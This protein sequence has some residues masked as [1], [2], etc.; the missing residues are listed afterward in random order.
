[1]KKVIL[2]SLLAFVAGHIVA[3][4]IQS[5]PVGTTLPMADIKMK[6]ISGKE[7]SINDAIKKN[8]VLVMFSCNTCPYVIKNQERTKETIALAEKNNIGVIILNS[9][10]DKREGDD[11]FEEMK[12]YAEKQ[13]YK[14][15]YTV[16]EAS[17]IADA[18]GATKTP[19]IF[20]FNSKNELIYK[21]AIDDNPSDAS[22]VT[23]KHL[24]EAV[25]ELTT[26]KPITI[27]ESKSVGCTIKRKS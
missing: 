11:S 16:D 10:E 26:G 4:N 20:L 3:Q 22:Q 18:F 2:F 8:G 21:G 1:M 25:S 6:D 27:K 14:C 15:Y 13:G 19:E 12:T 7:V 5:I 23:R 9:N 17:K 24:K